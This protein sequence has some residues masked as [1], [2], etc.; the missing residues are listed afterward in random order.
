MTKRPAPAGSGKNASY[1]AELRI[2]R[3]SE[4]EQHRGQVHAP[5]PRASHALHPGTQVAEWDG[6]P[7]KVSATV[8]DDGLVD[9]HVNDLDLTM[10]THDPAA[11]TRPRGVLD[12][13]Q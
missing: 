2:D 13:A 6:R 10:W 9:I 5:G 7:T 1:G 3:V 12:R 4:V 8:H 11:L